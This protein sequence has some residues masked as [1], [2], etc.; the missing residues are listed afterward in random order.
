MIS[1]MSNDRFVKIT[2]LCYLLAVLG[3]AALLPRQAPV[4]ADDLSVM[5]L[6]KVTD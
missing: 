3:V 1:I 2:L 6:H 5:G 4:T